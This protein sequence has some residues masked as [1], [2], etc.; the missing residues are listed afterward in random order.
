[1]THQIDKLL[2]PVL[3]LLLFQIQFSSTEALSTKP[4]NAFRKPIDGMLS[5][6]R[7][8]F[9]QSIALWSGFCVGKSFAAEAS[10]SSS[11]SNQKDDDDPRVYRLLSGVQF[12]DVRIGEGPLVFKANET[13]VLNLRAMTT[14]G[15]VLFDTR[16]DQNG[17]PLLYKFGS[18]QDF[19]FFGGDPSKR[20]KITPG[21]EDAIL[22]RG[23]ATV[24]RIEGR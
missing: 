11:S 7:L 8:F 15:T 18:S 4:S 19:D 22:S 6:R 3:I 12:R 14:D 24:Q 23:A 20:S 9:G 21:V 1:M 2:L 13:V 16:E 10:P 5:H 17:R